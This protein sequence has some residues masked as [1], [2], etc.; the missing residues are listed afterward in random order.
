MKVYHSLLLLLFVVLTAHGF[1]QKPKPYRQAYLQAMYI[2]STEYYGQE[3]DSTPFFGNNNLL[4]LFTGEQVF[5]DATINQNQLSLRSMEVDSSYK[6]SLGVLL[7]Q[8]HTGSKH[9]SVTLTIT[10]NLKKDVWVMVSAFEM[11]QKNWGADK[12]LLIPKRKTTTVVWKER[13]TSVLISD[14]KLK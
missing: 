3:L 12:P 6:P 2:D 8:Q 7:E 10:N 5:I 9:N 14:W 1:A 11:D 13:I 4:Q